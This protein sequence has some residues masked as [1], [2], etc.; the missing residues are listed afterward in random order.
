METLLRI[1]ERIAMTVNR[2]RTFA[3]SLSSVAAL[4][5]AACS[6]GGGSPSTSTPPRAA[7]GPAATKLGITLVGNT[8]G[9]ASGGF[10]AMSR[11]LALAGTPV[12]VT[13]NGVAVASGTLDRDGFVQLQFSQAVPAGSTV[14]VTVGS[15]AS[16]LVATVPLV[17]AIPAT[18]ALFTYDPGP[19]ATFNV[20]RAEDTADTGHFDVSQPEEE[21]EN[22][23][24]QTGEVATV[25]DDNDSKLP[26]NLP[27]TVTLCGST[28][29]VALMSAAPAGAYTLL[30]QEKASD[31]EDK[32]AIAYVVNPF[33][34]PA[35]F[36][37]SSTK[38]RVRIE[39][40]RDGQQVLEVKAPLGAFSPS[41]TVPQAVRRACRRRPRRLHLRLLP[42]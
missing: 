10:K 12:T 21:S 14:V 24:S 5:L 13:F 4:A 11:T 7:V 1:P 16:A 41:M 15:G 33:K 23:N 38:S 30:F 17:N 26:S 34:D 25:S 36:S 2:F 35:T 20:K 8:A 28:A 27:I 40:D 31:N 22:E 42:P 29:T 18:A 39:L 37:L 19:P 6:G 3:L 32:D 9:V